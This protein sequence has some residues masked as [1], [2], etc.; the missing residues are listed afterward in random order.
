MAVKPRPCRVVAGSRP[1]AQVALGRALSA[2]R[3]E[4]GVTQE[5]LSRRTGL[6]PTYISD[7][8]RGTRNP[9][10]STLVRWAHGLEVSLSRVAADYER[11]DRPT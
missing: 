3:G 9:S 4:L 11:L 8:E 10:F 7:V 1:P 2:L 5:E 6:H